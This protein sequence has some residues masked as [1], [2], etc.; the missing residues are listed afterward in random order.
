M[1]QEGLFQKGR[2]HSREAWFPGQ[3][4]TFLEQRTYIKHTQDTIHQSSERYSVANEQVSATLMLG[5]GLIWEG[6]HTFPSQE[7]AFFTLMVRAEVQCVL[8]RA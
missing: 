7:S 4:N 5:K 1:T 2:K 8:D 3:S 6:M